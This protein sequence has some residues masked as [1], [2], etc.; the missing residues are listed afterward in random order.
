MLMDIICSVHV[1]LVCAVEPVPVTGAECMC[2]L[3]RYSHHSLAASRE[4]TD[5]LQCVWL[6][7][8]TT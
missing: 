5:S 8:Q 6:L 4:Q 1:G 2:Q 7:L 3:R